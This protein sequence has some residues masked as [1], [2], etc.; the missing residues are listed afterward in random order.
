MGAAAAGRE[1]L[2]VRNARLLAVG[3]RR[4]ELRTRGA[5][6]YLAAGVIVAGMAV[7]TPG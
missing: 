5:L 4:G 7:P 2:N 1:P 3:P 6:S